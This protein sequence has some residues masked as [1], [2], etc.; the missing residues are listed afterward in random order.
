[1]NKETKFLIFIRWITF[2]PIKAANT[3]INLKFHLTQDP[4]QT[5]LDFDNCFF[6][7]AASFN[8]PIPTVSWQ[9][10][11]KLS[12]W[13]YE[14]PINIT[15]NLDDVKVEASFS[16]KIVESPLIRSK[17]YNPITGYRSIL[18]NFSSLYKSSIFSDFTFFV[19]GKEFKVH[20]NILAAASPVL[21][22]LFSSSLQEGQDDLCKVEEIKPEIFESLLKFVYEAKLPDNFDEQAQ[23]LYEA[24][25]YY[26]LKL[27]KKICEQRV[28]S[29]LSLENAVELYCWAYTYDT[30]K[31]KKEAWDI[32]K[33]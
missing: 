33:R 1:M 9:K 28:H 12:T 27:L 17:F 22:R 2:G 8:G 18:D 11:S 6:G 29:Q 21:N 25:H 30:I 19:K 5:D 15:G 13:T 16:I 32:V 23:D 7:T 3:D 24:A 26:E 4:S 20:K 14:L 31:L 10:A